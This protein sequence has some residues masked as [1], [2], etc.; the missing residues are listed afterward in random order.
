MAKLRFPD[1]LAFLT[2][3]NLPLAAGSFGGFGG[4]GDAFTGR[5]G[6]FDA[7]STQFLEAIAA[8]NA[9]AVYKIPGHDVSK[10]YPGAPID[11]WRLHLSALDMSQPPTYQFSDGK[12]FIGYSMTIS[13]PPALLKANPDGGGKMVDTD[14]S[15]GMCM[16]AY[17][18]PNQLTK[19]RYNNPANKPL[20]A[21]GS[22]AGFL[23]DA[24][25]AALEKAT[26]DAYSVAVSAT[27][28]RPLRLPRPMQRSGHARRVRRDL[29]EFWDSQV[30]N[31]WVL[32]TAM[33][34]V[35]IDPD[36]ESW[37]P[38]P[39]LPSVH[40]VAPNGQG[41]GKGF[42]FSGVVPA[43]ALNG[44]GEEDGGGNVGAG[45]GGGDEGGNDAGA[46]NGGDE[47]GA[48]LARNRRPSVPFQI[49]NHSF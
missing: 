33:V 1:L 8:S 35:T 39:G 29:Q 28:S 48:R 22:C 47:N 5:I 11:G 4:Y 12:P 30:L 44:D 20:A 14:P 17:G 42:T 36:R 37:N 26:E 40:C 49:H 15:W 2:I 41:T 18:H 38:G 10:P 27:T 45:N 24:C 16:W 43:N 32:V 19:E 34:N 13:A 6:P 23:S 25:I 31:Y 21:D 46:G 9:T 3:A 7:N